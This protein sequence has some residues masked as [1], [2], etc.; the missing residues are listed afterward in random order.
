MM[1]QRIRPAAASD[2]D[3]GSG[4]GM[5]GPGGCDGEGG[6]EG[7]YGG[8][9]EGGV[10]EGDGGDV[11]GGVGCEGE[12]GVGEG[13]DEVTQQRVGGARGMNPPE[14]GGAGCGAGLEASSSTGAAL[15]GQIGEPGRGSAVNSGRS[16]TT[17]VVRRR[18]VGSE[19]DVGYAGISESRLP[20][21]VRAR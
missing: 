16:G 20:Q 15:P 14:P 17:G 21:R 6:S 19:G 2:N 11:G 7:K 10:G 5:G 8:G 4:V 3:L 9:C 1:N 13:P 12:L 18:S